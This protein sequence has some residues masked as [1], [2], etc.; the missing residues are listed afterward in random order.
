MISSVGG[1]W[2]G[3]EDAAVIP[4]VRA[5]YSAHFINAL[6]RS[7]A[8]IGPVLRSAG[9][10]ESALEDPEGLTTIWQLGEVA[11]L[12]AIRSDNLDIG[13][14]ASETASLETYGEFSDKVLSGTSLLNR[15]RAFC[16]A[17]NDEYSEANFSIATSPRGVH[18][19]RGP[20]LGD[21]L[22]ARQTELYVLFM[23]LST[24]RSVL[25]PS[26]HPGL[27]LLQ[28]YYRPASETHFDPRRTELRFEQSQTVVVIDQKDL[29]CSLQGMGQ[30]DRQPDLQALSGD[31]ARAIGKLL[32]SHLGDRRLSLRFLAKICDMNPRTLQRALASQGM[33]FSD[34]LARQ[35]IAAAVG[36]LK[37]SDISIAELS[38][39][40][41]YS[42]Q[43]HFSRAFSRETGLSP[44]Q[45][46]QALQ[47]HQVP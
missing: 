19:R 3:W 26:W 8:A 22:S 20:I 40:L 45:Y 15:L 13:W 30:P 44:R 36:S 31:T 7:G 1:P 28:T 43:A 4:L 16:E 10:S 18:F 2:I 33:T 21:A 32:E 35:R 39:S 41:G 6:R 14:A 37:R 34:L 29:A 38:Y 12:S 27:V 17:A 24:V 47:E 42:H 46:R 25:G 9:L 23:M 5:R 11:R